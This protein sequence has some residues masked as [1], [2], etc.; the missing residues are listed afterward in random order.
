MKDLI[1]PISRV[2]G[3]DIKPSEAYEYKGVK[4]MDLRELENDL[5]ECMEALINLMKGVQGLPPLTAI[6][7]SL[8]KEWQSACKLIE[9]KTSRKWE[10]LKK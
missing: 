10:D 5:R 3:E 1:K 7:G 6:R 2:N 4:E 8:A 9:D